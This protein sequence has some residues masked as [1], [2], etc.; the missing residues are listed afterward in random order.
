ERGNAGRPGVRPGGDGRPP[1]APPSRSGGGGVGEHPGQSRRPRDCVDDD[2][3]DDADALLGP[4]KRVRAGA[5]PIGYVG[6]SSARRIRRGPVG[7]AVDLRGRP[8]DDAD[9]G[10]E[11]A[12]GPGRTPGPPRA[13][14]PNPPPPPPLPPP[15]TA[16]G[17]PPLPPPGVHPRRVLDPR[18]RQGADARGP[19]GRGPGTAPAEGQGAQLRRG[20]GVRA[21]RGV[22]GEKEGSGREGRGR[23]RGGRQ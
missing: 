23:E 13:V 15:P 22:D 3:H 20:G 14:P 1:S 9:D 10:L 19:R 21:L 16:P 18:Q 17:T 7:R 5:F 2:E 6:A 12:P 11:Y 8:D 4:P